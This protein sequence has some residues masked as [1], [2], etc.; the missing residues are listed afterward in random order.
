MIHNLQALW[1]QGEEPVICF[2]LL[3]FR[4]FEKPQTIP[5]WML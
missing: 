5:D 4:H 1:E 2:C 3:H